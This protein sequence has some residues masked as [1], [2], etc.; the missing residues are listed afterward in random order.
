L[1]YIL[2]IF[3]LPKLP[4]I[5]SID[6]I[7]EKDLWLALFSALTEED[8]VKLVEIG[9][10]F[11]AQVVEAYR[12]I[13]ATEEFRQLE[14]LREKTRLDEAQAIGSAE[15]RGAETERQKWQFVLAEKDTALAEKDTILADQA[16][17][18]AE[19]DT[20]LAD[21]ARIIAEL[22]AQLSKGRGQRSED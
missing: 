4:D 18:L 1:L 14:R 15:R 10:E 12:S 17:A 6:N 22:N 7:S 2:P 16:T 3:E 13:I 11:M 9:G 8:L 19:K 20:A 5:D 21:Q